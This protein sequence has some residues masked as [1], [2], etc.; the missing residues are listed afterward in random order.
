MRCVKEIKVCFWSRSFCRAL[1]AL[2]LIGMLAFSGCPPASGYKKF[3]MRAIICHYSLEYPSHY[4]VTKKFPGNNAD[5]YSSFA[6]RGTPLKTSIAIP[7]ASFGTSKIGEVVIYTSIEIFVYDARD[8]SGTA[9][10]D[11]EN[12]LRSWSRW[13]HFEL[14]ERSSITVSGIPAQKFSCF[15]NRILPSPGYG[16]GE[17]PLDFISVIYFDYGGLIWYLS[18][19]SD[20]SVSGSAA[21]DFEHIVQTFKIL[22]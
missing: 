16:Q 21:D 6:L 7:D 20:R 15:M 14:L 13:S 17:P 2:L 3:E 11:F 12:L 9:E 10:I 22:E 5:N 18:V 4:R 19:K 8:R 1:L